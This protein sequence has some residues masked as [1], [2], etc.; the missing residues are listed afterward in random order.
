MMAQRLARFRLDL[1]PLKRQRRTTSVPHHFIKMTNQCWPSSKRVMAQ[2][3]GHGSSSDSALASTYPAQSQHSRIY[4]TLK[5]H[6][7]PQLPSPRDRKR[8]SWSCGGCDRLLHVQ[9]GRWKACVTNRFANTPRQKERSGRAWVCVSNVRGSVGLWACG[10]VG[11]WV[12]R[13]VCLWVCGIG[14]LVARWVVGLVDRWFGGRV[15][16]VG[17]L[18]KVGTRIELGIGTVEVEGKLPR[19][20]SGFVRR[21]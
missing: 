11:I 14:G 19:L 8:P 10:H 7:R 18:G 4:H 2:S 17:K 13:F 21:S 6:F 1:M 5:S 16:N 12:C 9:S 15:E 20:G 3:H